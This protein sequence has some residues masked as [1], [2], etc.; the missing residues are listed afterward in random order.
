VRASKR[1]IVIAEHVVPGDVIRRQ[2]ELCVVPGLL[3]S[4]VVQLSFAAHPNTVFARTIALPRQ[5]NLPRMLQ[6][7]QKLQKKIKIGLRRR[8]VGPG[9]SPEKSLLM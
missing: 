7:P 2:P 6:P 9:F 1:T 8:H 5:L 3:I 4:H